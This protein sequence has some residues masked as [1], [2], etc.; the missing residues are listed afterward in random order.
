MTI[1]PRLSFFSGRDGRYYLLDFARAMPAEAIPEGSRRQIDY[2]VKLLRPELVRSYGVPLSPDTFSPFGAA[3]ERPV[4]EDEVAR[5]T[6]YLHNVL[7]PRC[8]MELSSLLAVFATTNNINNIAPSTSSSSSS[9]SSTPSSSFF[10]SPAPHQHSRTPSLSGPNA[11]FEVTPR[12]VIANNQQ[13]QSIDLQFAQSFFRLKEI[14]HSSGVNLRHLGEVVKVLVAGLSTSALPGNPN[15]VP[16]TPLSSKSLSSLLSPSFQY[17]PTGSSF[18]LS[19]AAA[20]ASRPTSTT[21]PTS[22]SSC[23]SPRSP[24]SPTT[25][26]HSPASRSTSIPAL[27]PA[28]S[29]SS[30]TSTLPDPPGL[31]SEAQRLR[32]YDCIRLLIMEMLVRVFKNLVRESFREKMEQTKQPMEGPFRILLADY[33]NLFLLNTPDSHSFWERHLVKLA[34]NQFPGCSIPD[35]IQVLLSASSFPSSSSDP[36]V[37]RVK[38]VII[39][40]DHLFGVP[41][42]GRTLLLLRVEKVLGVKFSPVAN[43]RLFASNVRSNFQDASIVS[44]KSILIH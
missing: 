2:L 24:T 19:G 22:P 33:L 3:V 35:A 7:I 44:S 38:D 36:S 40:F 10:S 9:S 6:E 15:F 5:A 31:P 34:E 23:T 13:Y 28:P 16:Y 41:M 8:A 39:G 43:R 12:G 29:P 32:Q 1:S 20:A 17:P 4:C 27:S 18:N 14:I 25:S 11:N 30:S 42:R 37:I 26:H 21:T